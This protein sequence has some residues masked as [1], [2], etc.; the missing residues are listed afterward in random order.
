M[1]FVKIKDCLSIFIC[2]IKNYMGFSVELKNINKSFGDKSILEN[3]DLKVHSG[4]SFVI[5][6]SSGTGK[7][8]MLKLIAGL[9]EP[10]DG[11]I[12]IDDV[13]IN[14]ATSR[15]KSDLWK[16]IGYLFQENALFDWLNLWQN[17]G[18]K[19]LFYY[20][21]KSNIV[22]ELAI[23]KLLSVGIPIDSI[24]LYPSQISGGMQKRVGIA[25]AIMHNPKLMLFDE[26][27]SGLDPIISNTINNLTINM[28]KKINATAI[29]ITHDINAAKIVGD[30]IG[31]LYRGKFIW[32]G[33]R[34]EFNS[35]DNTAI[36]QFINGNENGPLH[37]F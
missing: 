24:E 23:E 30:R 27:T 7:S 10:D 3:V 25:R 11:Q 29:T 16:N 12:F 5:L 18:F 14:E 2:N 34:A 17:V 31:L 9:I 6:G 19:D 13:V 37:L 33:T 21:K 15:V 20:N 22:K 36:Q 4:E 32:C 8:V 1:T 28:S 26:P 35:T